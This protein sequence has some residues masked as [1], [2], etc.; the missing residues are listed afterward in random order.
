M[1]KWGIITESSSPWMALVNFIPKKSEKLRICIDYHQLN[2]Q[3]VKDAYPLLLPDEI[4]DRLAECMV[5]TTLDL[6]SGYWQ[7]PEAW[8]CISS[9]VYLLALLH[10]APGSF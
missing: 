4:Q 10:G 8:A 5:F 2:K 7:L 6:H 3:T 9:A 1:L